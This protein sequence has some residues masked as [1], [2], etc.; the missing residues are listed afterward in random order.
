MALPVNLACLA[1]VLWTS[2]FLSMPSFNRFLHAQPTTVE[3]E[4]PGAVLWL[5][6][7]V[8]VSVCIQW[9]CR[10]AA[11]V[12]MVH[13]NQPSRSRCGD[14]TVSHDAKSSEL[15][16][17]GWGCGSTAATWSLRSLRCL[18]HSSVFLHLICFGLLW[19]Q[20]HPSGLT[21]IPR[22]SS[23]NS[24]KQRPR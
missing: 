6:S 14:L 4:F 11:P 12:S 20:T 8:F 18:C 9:K 10:I 23:H 13:L 21:N 19:S 22:S 24:N 17:A 3:D 7:F 15:A 16:R 2:A 5:H 1:R